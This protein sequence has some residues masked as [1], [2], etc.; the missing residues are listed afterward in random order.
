MFD[1][2]HAIPRRSSRAC[3]DAVFHRNVTAGDRLRLAG[4]AGGIAVAT[5]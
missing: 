2:R 1:R 3:H 5:A 4:R